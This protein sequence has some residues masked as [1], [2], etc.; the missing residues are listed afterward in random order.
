[1]PCL[2]ACIERSICIYILKCCNGH[3]I[4][5]ND[6]INTQLTV[7]IYTALCERREQRKGL[8]LG[9]RLCICR[10]SISAD[11]GSHMHAPLVLQ[12]QFRQR[13]L[14]LMQL[15]ISEPWT[16]MEPAAA[17]LL[18]VPWMLASAWQHG[19]GSPGCIASSL[20]PDCLTSRVR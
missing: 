11:G 9:V 12:I 20:D 4:C 17:A 7:H 10:V 19:S 15:S 16:C 18:Q 5:T 14:S 1:M 13:S 2:A 3:D 8:T 6:E